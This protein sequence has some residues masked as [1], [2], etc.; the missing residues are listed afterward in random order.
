M[1]RTRRTIATVRNGTLDMVRVNFA[2]LSNLV[3]AAIVPALPYFFRSTVQLRH[4]LDGPIGEEL[5]TELDRQELVGLC[6]ND[7]G[8]PPNYGTKPV[9]KAADLAGS[10]CA[11]PGRA[12]EC[13][14]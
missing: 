10:G 12:S 13:R 8:S 14:S 7:T 6:F 1:G 11:C 5:L 9:R 2:L 4:V 3:P